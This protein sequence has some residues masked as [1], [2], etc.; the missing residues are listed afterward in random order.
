[1]SNFWMG[2]AAANASAKLKPSA[3]AHH[4]L[5][6]LAGLA[7]GLLIGAGLFAIAAFTF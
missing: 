3:R 6:I 2:I 7:I 1:M 5:S 4:V